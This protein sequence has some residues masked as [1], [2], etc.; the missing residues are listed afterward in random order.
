MLNK[1]YKRYTIIGLQDFDNYKNLNPI[2]VSLDS[3]SLINEIFKH[4]K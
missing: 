3:N 1:I 2:E 4:E